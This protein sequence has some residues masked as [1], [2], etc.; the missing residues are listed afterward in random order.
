[1]PFHRET[2]PDD[3]LTPE[4]VRRL[5]HFKSVQ[6]VYRWIREGR[7]PAAK[8]SDKKI[9]IRRSAI[10][11]LLKQLESDNLEK[12]KNDLHVE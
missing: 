5:L 9:L 4:D 11:Q 2:C 12:V 7:I 10:Q 1:M 6:T 3:L 8:F